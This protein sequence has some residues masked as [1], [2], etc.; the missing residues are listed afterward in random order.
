MRKIQVM[1]NKVEKTIYAKEKK[2]NLKDVEQTPSKTLMEE[3]NVLSLHQMGAQSIVMMTRIILTTGKPKQL[4]QQLTSKEGRTGIY[5]KTSTIPKLNITTSNFIHKGVK[6]WN[7]LDQDIRSTTSTIAFKDRI[8]KW[9][10]TNIP[11]KPD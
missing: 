10:K 6:L 9:I 8:K 3:N 7:M 11:V 5:W 2:I 4:Y 1:Q